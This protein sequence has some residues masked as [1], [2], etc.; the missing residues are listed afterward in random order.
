MLQK[1]LQKE[2]YNSLLLKH[3]EREINEIRLRASKP[4]VV[5]CNSKPYFL[6]EYGVCSNANQA[7]YATKDLISNIVFKASDYSIYSVNEQI[8]QGFLTLEGGIRIGICGNAVVEDA[9]KTINEFNSVCIRIPH[10]IKNAAL[11]IFNQILNGGNINNT[12]IIS[13]PG[14]GKTT[15]LRDIVYQFSNHNYP[16]NFFIADERGEITGGNNAINLGNFCDSIC[17]L[18]KKDSILFGLR[19][20]SPDVIVTDELGAKD[21][22]DAL[23]YALNC[24]VKVVATMH[25]SSIEDLKTKPYFQ[26]FL[27]NKYFKRY[28][29]LSKENGAGTIDGV[30]RENLTRIYGGAI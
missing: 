6:G 25:A 22:F 13:P 20:M 27:E 3:N 16:Y 18:N 24:G 29:V 28:I 19:S 7:I 17:F 15:M 30:Y 8:K 26:K 12:L 9:I 10:L 1:I 4:I 2:I 5:I 11:P 23:E 14:A 21:D